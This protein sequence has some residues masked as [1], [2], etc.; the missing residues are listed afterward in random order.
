MASKTKPAIPIAILI[1]APTLDLVDAKGLE[2]AEVCAGGVMV[3]EV[4]IILEYIWK[5]PR[6]RS[7]TRVVIRFM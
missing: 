5:Y 3:A 4:L 7:R 1:F 6:T 2:S